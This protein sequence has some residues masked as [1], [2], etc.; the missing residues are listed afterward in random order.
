[1]GNYL[2]CFKIPSIH[3]DDNNL[4]DENI[5]TDNIKKILEGTEFKREQLILRNKTKLIDF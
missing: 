5:K 4:Y 2:N 3:I 1:M